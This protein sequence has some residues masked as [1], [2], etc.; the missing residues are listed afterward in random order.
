MLAYPVV[1]GRREAS[2][3]INIDGANFP[4]S[5]SFVL[6]KNN[7][8]AITGSPTII[9]YWQKMG[10]WV[11]IYIPSYDLDV[12]TVAD[13]SFTLSV[14]SGVVI[15]ELRPLASTEETLIGQVQIQYTPNTLGIFNA[16]VLV[17]QD[18]GATPY[19]RFVYGFTNYDVATANEVGYGNGAVPP[20]TNIQ[21][22][23]FNARY[24]VQV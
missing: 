17:T 20:R 18:G 9:V 2:S 12:T 13:A 11:D 10:K 7:V 23:P 16:N 5:T 4:N 19:V 1:Y 22:C 8:T 6:R 14:R 3:A 24:A 21:V 15:P